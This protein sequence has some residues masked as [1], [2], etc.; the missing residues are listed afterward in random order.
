LGVVVFLTGMT[1][2]GF[3]PGTRGGLDELVRL[4]DASRG[5]LE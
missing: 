2:A 5:V 4:L 1:T 3:I